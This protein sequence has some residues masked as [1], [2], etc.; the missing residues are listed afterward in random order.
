MTNS[1]KFTDSVPATS[2]GEPDF[3]TIIGQ[4]KSRIVEVTA[5][6]NPTYKVEGHSYSKGE[7]LE[8]LGRQL[9]Q[10]MKLRSQSEPFEI[11]SRGN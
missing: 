4:I 2:S 9:E 10:M 6:Q 1:S 8:Q 5:S 7:Y 3:D 11:V